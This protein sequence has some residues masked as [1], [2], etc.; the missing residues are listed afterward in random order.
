VIIKTHLTVIYW[1]GYCFC[2]AV[3]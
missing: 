3:C 1:R 2:G